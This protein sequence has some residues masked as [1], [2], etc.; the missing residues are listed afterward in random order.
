[1]AEHHSSKRS[2]KLLWVHKTAE[3]EHM[4]RSAPAEA[5]LI[6]SHAQ[7]WERK[8]RSSQRR[9]TQ[10]RHWS[11]SELQWRS[12]GQPTISDITQTPSPIA[13]VSD[14]QEDGVASGYVPD[15]SIT[16][17][18]S[19]SPHKIAEASQQA[20]KIPRQLCKEGTAIDPF[21][22]AIVNL[23]HQAH[24]LL[25]Y[26]V[27]TVFPPI[28]QT[29]AK[30]RFL[31]PHHFQ[32]A[33][34]EVVQDHISSEVQIVTL[35][36]SMASRM[37]HLDRRKVQFGS[38]SFINKAIGA[39]RK[40]LSTLPAVRPEDIAMVLHLWR[41]EIYRSNYMAA[42][43]HLRG[44]KDMTDQLGGLPGLEKLSPGLME[45]LI[46]GDL[47][48]AIELAIPPVFPCTWSPGRASAYG[49]ENIDKDGSFANMGSGLLC[50]PQCAVVTAVLSEIIEE[51]VECAKV[52]FS[53]WDEST[54][55][56]A[57]RFGFRLNM[58]IRHRLSSFHELDIRAEALRIALLVWAVM[59]LNLGSNYAFRRTIKVAT[60]RLKDTILKARAEYLSWNGHAK[61][62]M[63]MLV[64]GAMAL[65]G[66][67][68]QYWFIQQLV[69]LMTY[70][71]V[72]NTTELRAVLDRSLYVHTRQ[73]ISLKKLFD[74][75]AAMAHF[76]SRP[77][78]TA[79][80]MEILP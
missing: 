45:S 67:P 15:P 51:T 48:M 75:L 39:L 2:P 62:L 25:Q 64:V 78:D 22:T 66:E 53:V 76:N 1:M 5:S 80:C 46:V 28:W 65:E 72:E 54:D 4:S 43:T 50:G 71:H 24:I 29:I 68:E 19:G 79:Q 57:L 3:S 38:S 60:P 34:R 32:L 74:K 44:M 26:Y 59:V 16:V 77:T 6:N 33:A 37:E 10:T 40:H 47:F 42:W 11:S 73:C 52:M 7:R 70:T 31:Q 18:R 55:P 23:D 27:L 69:S 35:L 63:W 58:A 49:F 13:A 9:R 30:V 20:L 21:Q 36:A 56:R 61:I 14:S 17:T 12:P 8:V 41:A